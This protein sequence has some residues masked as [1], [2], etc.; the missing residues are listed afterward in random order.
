LTSDELDAVSAGAL[1]AYIHVKGQ[2]SGDVKVNGG[3]DPAVTGVAVAV[4][5]LLK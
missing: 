4:V 2:K 3:T 5:K 1:Q